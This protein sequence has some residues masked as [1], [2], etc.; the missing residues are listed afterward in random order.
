MTGHARRGLHARLT[1]PHRTAPRLTRAVTYVVTHDANLMALRH[2]EPLAGM[3]DGY[4]ACPVATG[5]GK[6]V[7]AEFDY[8]KTLKESFPFDQNQ[9]TFIGGRLSATELHRGFAIFLLGVAAYVVCANR[10]LLTGTADG[11]C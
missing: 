9:G 3:P 6:H 8:T 7:M 4:M 2:Y 5:Y 1:A 10:A 11:R